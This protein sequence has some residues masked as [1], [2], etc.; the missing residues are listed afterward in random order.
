MRW[1]PLSWLTRPRAPPRPPVRID[2]SSQVRPELLSS[3]AREF[4]EPGAPV[5]VG[6]SAFRRDQA[7]PLETMQR[8]VQS[9]ILDLEGASRTL[10]DASG[11][12]VPVGRAG[13]KGPEHEEVHGSHEVQ[14]LGAG[15][16]RGSARTGP[17]RTRR[18][19]HRRA[20]CAARRRSSHRH[21]ASSACAGGFTRTNRSSAEGPHV[22]GASA[23][24]F[25][26][27]PMSPKRS[28]AGNRSDR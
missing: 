1:L 21:D 8:L 25:R 28:S 5:V 2:A 15:G 12:P 4:V 19:A 26:P 7:L 16:G 6:D 17:A 10:F 24:R 20:E 23:R 3:V 13:R 9:R 14:R 18:A 27:T 22:D 11:H